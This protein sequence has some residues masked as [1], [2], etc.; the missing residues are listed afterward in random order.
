M[1]SA[2]AWMEKDEQSSTEACPG[3]LAILTS[4][5]FVITNWNHL[6]T[7][8]VAIC[9]STTY[10]DKKWKWTEPD[11]ITKNGLHYIKISKWDRNFVRFATG[12]PLDLRDYRSSG[13]NAKVLDDI[14]TKRNSASKQ[15]IEQELALL[16]DDANEDQAQ[17]LKRKVR[18]EDGD[19]LTT[20]FVSVDLPEFEHEGKLYGPLFPKILWAITGASFYIE[21]IE[22]NLLYIKHAVML[23]LETGDLG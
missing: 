1:A 20:P 21:A 9:F 2:N 11:I 4:M 17:K 16:A 5:W 3:E 18:P 15:A 23:G 13:A 19:L 12:R 6:T 8:L 22:Q 10:N 14:V 7:N